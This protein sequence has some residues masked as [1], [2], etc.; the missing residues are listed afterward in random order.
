VAFS[1][2]RIYGGALT[3]FPG[4][5]RDDSLRHVVVAQDAGPGQES[6]VSAE[7]T[8]VVRLVLEHAGTR[9]AESLG[10]IALGMRHAERIDAAVRAALSQ[11]GSAPLEAFFA[12]DVAEPFFVKNLER[13]QGD[14]R[15]AIILS[16]GYGKHR[17]GRM[18]YSGDRCCGRAASAD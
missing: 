18:R 9:P 17:D 4:V 12:E 16:V 14:E 2:D 1:N 6:S 5:A 8:E 11:A 10:V 3:T 15:D 13:V 7:V